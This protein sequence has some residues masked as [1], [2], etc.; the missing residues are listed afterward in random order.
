[1]ENL[2]PG[3]LQSNPAIRMRRWRGASLLAVLSFG[4]ALV[5]WIGTSYHVSFFFFLFIAILI[6]ETYDILAGYTGYINLGHG[7]FFGL[8]TSVE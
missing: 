6:T 2:G 3:P 1:M 5:P 4:A 7:A 8:A